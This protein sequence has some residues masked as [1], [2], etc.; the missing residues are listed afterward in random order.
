MVNCCY[1]DNLKIKLICNGSIATVNLRKHVLVMKHHHH[2]SMHPHHEELINSFNLK[3]DWWKTQ[4]D[5]ECSRCSTCW[6]RLHQC[7]CP[8]IQEKRRYYDKMLSHDHNHENAGHDDQD[9]S[10][11]NVKVIMYYSHQE[12]GRSAN[13]AHY[14]QAICPSIC[15]NAII[16]G[17]LLKEIELMDQIEQEFA[18]QSP[19]T[20]ILFPW[21]AAICHVSSIV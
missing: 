5:I 20:V 13:T 15:S 7:Y 6:L 3:I 18:T 4:T 2:Q 9:S 1:F 8:S 19:Q 17:D 12:I 10:L 21:L 14:L 11:C 16:H